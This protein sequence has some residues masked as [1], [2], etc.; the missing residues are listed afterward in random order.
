MGSLIFLFLVKKFF[1]LPQIKQRKIPQTCPG[2]IL[3]QKFSPQIR[4][5]E[6]ELKAYKPKIS[7]KYIFFRFMESFCVNF[8]HGSFE[9]S[10]R[11]QI[12]CKNI[13]TFLGIFASSSSNFTPKKTNFDIFMDHIMIWR[14][15][16]KTHFPIY[17]PKF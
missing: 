3:V 13:W 12:Y 14:R 4:S 15:F 5:R 1:F 6:Q 7:L 9:A 17:R 2:T 10:F 16:D 8:S 11:D